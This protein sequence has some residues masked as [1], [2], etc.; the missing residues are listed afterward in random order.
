VQLNL[1]C[2]ILYIIFVCLTWSRLYQIKNN[3]RLVNKIKFRIKWIKNRKQYVQKLIENSSKN[4][5]KC[6]HLCKSLDQNPYPE[7]K[8]LTKKTE[9]CK[10]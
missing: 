8:I 3:S 1:F 10:K 9:V 5:L 7:T 4:Y 6:K 2:Q